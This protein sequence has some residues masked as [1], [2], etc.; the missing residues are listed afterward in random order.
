MIDRRSY[1]LPRC[2]WPEVY[3]SWPGYRYSGPRVRSSILTPLCDRISIGHRSRAHRSGAGSMKRRT[4]V[5]R[6]AGVRAELDSG[7]HINGPAQRPERAARAPVRCS[8]ELGHSPR[9]KWSKIIAQELT[10]GAIFVPLGPKDRELD[11]RTD[12]RRSLAKEPAMNLRARTKSPGQKLLEVAQSPKA[13][14]HRIAG[15]VTVGMVLP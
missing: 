10:R 8:V 3:A 11:F 7:S 14:P 13:P 1:R 2:R 4:T 6:A 5:R 12:A 9:R 15:D